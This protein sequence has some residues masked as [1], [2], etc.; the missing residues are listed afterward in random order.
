LTYLGH[1]QH[2]PAAAGETLDVTLYWRVEQEVGGRDDWTFFAHLVDERGFR[3][4]GETF[5]H[6]PSAQWQPGEMILY[7]KSIP[8]DAGAPPGSYKLDL[9]AFSPSLDARLPVLDEA[10]QLAGTAIHVG[11][12]ELDRAAAPP[13][14]YPVMQEEHDVRFAEVL[15][16]LGSDRD[17]SDLRPGETLALTLHWLAEDRVPPDTTIQLWLQGTQRRVPLWEGDPV[18]GDYAFTAWQPPEYVRDRYALR[19]PLEI[20]AGDYDLHLA[21]LDP[22]GNP[23]AVRSNGFSRSPL[24]LGTLHV[25]ASDRLWEPPPFDHAVNA[26][27]GDVIELVG[28][29]LEPTGAVVQPGDTLRLTLVWRCLRP[30]ERPYTVFTHLLDSGQQVRGQKDNPPVGGRYP[31]T[32]WVP[33]EIVVD[34]YEITVDQDAPPDLYVLEVGIYDPTTGVRLPVGSATGASADRVL[35]GQ[36]VLD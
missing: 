22:D 25:H 3:W 33:D 26:R 31:T 4:G 1:D 34:P 7:E 19:L 24:K 15:T 23:L 20:E 9:G 14:A 30:I 35:L 2:G 5:F 10:G 11:P 6:Y 18:R 27:L 21:L 16:L 29:T 32:L 17:R 36:I 13:A 28:Y 12:I 8:V